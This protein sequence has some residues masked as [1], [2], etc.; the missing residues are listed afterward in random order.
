MIDRLLY[1]QELKRKILELPHV[2]E[3]TSS[4][5]MF[6]RFQTDADV[7]FEISMIGFNDTRFA[8][9]FDIGVADSNSCI[10]NVSW[11][12]FRDKKHWGCWEEIYK[13]ET[14]EL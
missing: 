3:I 5:M 1:I 12:E 13:V 14:E 10:G 7:I 6:V 4:D 11:L 8:I 2:R 9:T